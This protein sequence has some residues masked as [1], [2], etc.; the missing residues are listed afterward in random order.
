MLTRRK[1][2]TAAAAGAATLSTFNRLPGLGAAEYDLIIAGGR[3]IDPS[4]AFDAVADVA[5]AGGKI[6]A[7]R[8]GLAP[9]SAAATIDAR[10]KLVVPGLIDI[11]TH[12]GRAMADPAT[13]LSQGVTSL[14]DAGS[15]GADHVDE[16]VAVAKAAPNRMRVLINIAK[17]GILDEGELNDI[18]HADVAATRAAIERNRDFVV[19]IKARLSQNVAGKNDVEALRRAQQVAKPLNIPVMIHMGQTFSPLPAIF[20]LLKPGDIVTHIYAPP[21]HGIFD[22]SG[23]VLPEVIDA[24]R[25]GVWFDIGNGRTGHITWAMATHAME[26]RLLPDTVSTDW[27][28]N[29]LARTEQV[30]DFGNVLSKFLMLG[31]PLSDVIAMATS[32]AAKTFPAFKGLGTLSVGVPADVTVLELREGS[33]D[34]F[35]NERAKRSGMQRLFAARTLFGGKG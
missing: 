1:F 29:E 19:G 34:F 31:V 9:A 13:C 5:I 11:H 18:S 16:I 27:T 22:E 6:A 28:T 2:L 30:I 3:V 4:H 32:N 26:S 10:G 21:P 14:I 25:R 12:A 20:A 24:R 17:T 23:R 8:P 35:D 7:V 33:F 15:Q